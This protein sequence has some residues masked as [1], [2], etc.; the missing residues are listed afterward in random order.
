[1]NAPKKHW[2]MLGL[3]LRVALPIIVLP[4]VIAAAGTPPRLAHDREVG[5]PEVVATFSGPMPTGVAVSRAGRIFINYPRW[6]DD[7]R[8]TVAEV[9]GGKPVPYPS[10][11]LNEAGSGKP[12]ERLIA[13]QSVVVDP[14]DRLWILDT[15]SIE[16]KPAAP[17]AAKLVGVDLKTN[18]VFKTIVFP[19]ETALPTTYL[20]DVRF[21]LRRGKEGMAFITDSSDKGPNG[22]IVVDLASGRSWRRLNDHPSTKAD[23]NYLPVVEGRPLLARPSPGQAQPLT[24]GSDG[25]AISP[26]GKRL[27]Y[28]P[29]VG[30]RLYSVSVDAL[31]DE[32]LDDAAV[33]K[34]VEDLGDKGGASDGL[35]SDADGRVYLTNYEH[36][37]ILARQPDG[38][39]ETLAHDPRI[40]WPDTLSVAADGHLYFTANQ[41]NRQKRFCEGKDL[42]QQPYVLFRIPIQG[43]PI[44]DEGGR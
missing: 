42:R 19:P 14:R 36:N 43:R 13:V 4:L 25:I 22:I 16:F 31:A 6:G 24:L 30:R 5:K 9:V 29:L 32:K 23:R 21:D 35:E 28:C 27:Y 39:L 10:A 40:L 37:A 8:F 11:E 17:G 34:T 1:M 26:D 38:R 2:A 15:G 41:L 3:A 18:T 20:N 44:T 33:G 12:S 7:V